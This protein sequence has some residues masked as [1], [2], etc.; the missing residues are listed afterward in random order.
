MTKEQAQT[1]AI[2]IGAIV[3]AFRLRR[4][5]QVRL[6][7]GDLSWYLERREPPAEVRVAVTTERDGQRIEIQ[8]WILDHENAELLIAHAIK[9]LDWPRRNEIKGGR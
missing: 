2:V 7:I 1:Q 9:S 6:S 3:G 5:R 4:A 8:C